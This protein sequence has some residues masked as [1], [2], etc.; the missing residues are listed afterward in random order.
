MEARLDDVIEFGAVAVRLTCQ[1]IHAD[2][3]MDVDLSPD[4]Q[5]VSGNAKSV[6]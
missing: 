2:R 4:D 5:S 3:D 1:E 6:K